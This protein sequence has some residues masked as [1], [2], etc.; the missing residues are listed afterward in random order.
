MAWYTYV[1]GEI[2][3]CKE[4]WQNKWEVEDK[5]KENNEDIRRAKEQIMMLVASSPKNLF[6][7]QDADGYDTDILNCIQWKM[8]DLWEQIET[9]QYHNWKLEF[10]LEN[11]DNRYGDFIDN[12]LSPH[13][14][15]SEVAQ[16]DSSQLKLDFEQSEEPAVEPVKEPAMEPVK[17]PAV[18]PVKENHGLG[19]LNNNIKLNEVYGQK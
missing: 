12:P 17:E 15:I 11:W 3:F 16:E 8:Q 14:N 6:Q 1:E 4:T 18:E 10:L 2:W 19:S 7:E 5:I 9:A 13:N